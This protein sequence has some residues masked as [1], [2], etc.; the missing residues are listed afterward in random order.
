MIDEPAEIIRRAVRAGRREVA[1]A[2]IAPR[3]VKRVLSDRQQLNVR[4]AGFLHVLHEL[5][6]E[7]TVVEEAPIGGTPP[8]A[9]MNF[10]NGHG[11]VS[12]LPF[13]ATAY[14]FLVVPVM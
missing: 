14:P 9:E 7:F 1:G 10:V 8:G 2:L 5:P 13:A 6:R 11:A 4:E 3:V 12:P